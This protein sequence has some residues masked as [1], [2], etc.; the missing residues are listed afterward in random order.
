MA[1]LANRSKINYHFSDAVKLAQLV[2]KRFLMTGLISLS[3]A[4]LYYSVPRGA[5][6]ICLEA[7][8][9]LISSGLVIYQQLFRPLNFITEKI[10]YWQDLEAENLQLR[11]QAA[12]S[13]QLS[14]QIQLMQAENLALKK[15]LSVAIDPEYCRVTAKLLSV[16]LNPFSKTA[17]LGAGTNDGVMTEQIVT[18]NDGIIGRIIEVSKNYARVMLISDANSCIPVITSVSRQRSILKGCNGQISLNYL[19]DNHAVQAGEKIVTSGDGRLYPP[20]LVVAVVTKLSSTGE[21]VIE[22]VA[23][24]HAT[25]FV[26]IHINPAPAPS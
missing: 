2:M 14:S 26:T 9:H 19:P 8:G 1:I 24:L 11:S 5:S 7:S 12:R 20:G 10:R 13:E 16:S 6:A 4:W 18:N 15:L 25:E 21:L 17:L 23:S 3:V 22:P